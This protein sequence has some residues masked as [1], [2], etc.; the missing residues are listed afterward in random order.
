V[1][2]SK[3]VA[4]RGKTSVLSGEEARQLLDSTDTSG[5]VCLRG[6]AL[7]GV[8]TYAFAR[9]SAAVAMRLGDYYPQG[10]QW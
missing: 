2:A 8:L 7:V 4:K 9:V 6:R 3:Y 5:V 1:R 10:K